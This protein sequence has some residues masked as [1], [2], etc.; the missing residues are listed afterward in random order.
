[1]IILLSSFLGI[2]IGILALILPIFAGLLLVIDKRYTEKLGSLSNVFLTAVVLGFSILLFPMLLVGLLTNNGYDYYHYIIIAVLLVINGLILKRESKRINKFFRDSFIKLQND[3]TFLVWFI[4]AIFFAIL[5]FATPLIEWDALEYYLLYAKVFGDNGHIVMVDNTDTRGLVLNIPPFTSLSYLYLYKVTGIWISTKLYSFLWWISLICVSRSLTREFMGDEDT[6]KISGLVVAIAPITMLLLYES[7]VYAELINI[8]FLWIGVLFLVKAIKQP[9]YRFFFLISGLAFAIGAMSK[10]QAI[11]WAFFLIIIVIAFFLNR[12]KRLIIAIYLNVFFLLFGALVHDLNQSWF[13]V[14]WLTFATVTTFFMVYSTKIQR[15][16]L[17]IKEWLISSSFFLLPFVFI[18]SFWIKLYFQTGQ[19]SGENTFAFDRGGVKYTF[20]T[21][22]IKNELRTIGWTSL[23]VQFLIFALTLIIL[24]GILKKN[25]DLL[26]APLAIIPIFLAI[27][28]EKALFEPWDFQTNILEYPD[29]ANFTGYISN[30]PFSPWFLFF[31]APL[32]GSAYLLLKIA[33]SATIMRS[34]KVYP[35]TLIVFCLAM[36]RPL[37]SLVTIRYVALI[38]V[39]LS[40]LAAFG[41][42]TFNNFITKKNS[43]KKESFQSLII[44]WLVLL[45][46]T[47]FNWRWFINKLTKSDIG[48]SGGD[49]RTKGIIEWLK[50]A[51]PDTPFSWDMIEVCIVLSSLILATVISIKITQ[52]IFTKKTSAKMRKIL[53]SRLKNHPTTFSIISVKTKKIHHI[54]KKKEAK[55]KIERVFS[56]VLICIILTSSFYVL[57]PNG[58]KNYHDESKNDWYDGYLHVIDFIKENY[59][60]STDECILAIGD[61]GLRLYTGWK[62]LDLTDGRSNSIVYEINVNDPVS[63]LGF[64]LEFNIR[65]V[66]LPWIWN[67]WWDQLQT[68]WRWI[69]LFS[70]IGDSRFFELVSQFSYSWRLYEVKDYNLTTFEGIYKITL[71]PYKIP[72]LSGKVSFP[73]NVR[74]QGKPSETIPNPS[75]D[76]TLYCPLDSFWE[77]SVWYRE[78]VLWPLCSGTYHYN[79]TTFNKNQGGYHSVTFTFPSLP[80]EKPIDPEFGEAT[81]YGVE[82]LNIALSITHNNGITTTYYY[83]STINNDEIPFGIIYFYLLNSWDI[84]HDSTA[85]LLGNIIEINSSS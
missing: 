77:L 44:L 33:G 14:E 75:I 56:L 4:M 18:S 55:Q 52:K 82:I 63:I 12:L 73:P 84:V 2:V 67:T 43:N 81:G 59:P 25:E 35:L 29:N 26:L 48:R 64:F 31:I 27:I 60:S 49:L 70:F 74:F 19:I 30:F 36:W 61:Y 20:P 47:V 54:I 85:F 11:L 65:L 57:F 17:R 79:V 21:D 32:F 22:F 42:T 15:G 7:S 37:F 28:A 9:Q 53:T 66:V 1:V 51:N 40:I 78:Y 80:E 38:V 3:E 68:S 58:I 6:A 13:L 69:R 45:L 34:K 76:L 62:V 46:V 16:Y 50:Y 41:L 5:I 71:S 83:Y 23:E 24:A 72:L 39:P 8:T 10:V